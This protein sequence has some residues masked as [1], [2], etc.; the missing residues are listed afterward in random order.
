[1][2]VGT[3]VCNWEDIKNVSFFNSHREENRFIRTKSKF[4]LCYVQEKGSTYLCVKYQVSKSCRFFRNRHLVFFNLCS[5]LPYDKIQLPSLASL[6]LIMIMAMKI[7]P[8]TVYVLRDDV[9]AAHHRAC[10]PELRGVRAACPER[11]EDVRGCHHLP[12]IRRLY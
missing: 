10:R 3:T 12:R 5:C 6:A 9:C 4:R 11:G 8:C 2:I 1:M 7:I